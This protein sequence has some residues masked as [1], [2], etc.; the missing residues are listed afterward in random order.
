MTDPEKPNHSDISL[1]EKIQ[2][3]ESLLEQQE[4]DTIEFRDNIPV[5]DEL[6]TE[7]DYLDMDDDGIAGEF[8]GYSENIPELAQKLEEKFSAE[9]D[10]VVELLKGNLKNSIMEELRH[11][12]SG[13]EPSKPDNTTDNDEP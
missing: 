7:A 3:L 12:I 1:N 5:L 9:L 2:E 11:Q 4:S 8:T 10:Q 6:V 13:I